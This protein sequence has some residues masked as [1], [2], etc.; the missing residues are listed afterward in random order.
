[1]KAVLGFSAELLKISLMLAGAFYAFEV[2]VK[3]ARFRERYQ[4][5]VTPEHPFRSAGQ[6]LIGAGVLI[7]AAI[8]TLSRPVIDMLGE[9]SA[10]VGEWALAK[11]Q[12]AAHPQD[13]VS[14]AA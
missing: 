1:M 11:R 4:P 14:R 2:L 9:A 5:E 6:L 8:V 10:E 7:T 12:A 13:P 3:F